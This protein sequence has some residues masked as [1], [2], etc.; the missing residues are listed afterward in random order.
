MIWHNHIF[1]YTDILYAIA[2][3]NVFFNNSAKGG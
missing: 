2:E 3:N 1:V